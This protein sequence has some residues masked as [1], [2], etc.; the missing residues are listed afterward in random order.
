MTNAVSTARPR[1]KKQRPTVVAAKPVKARPRKNPIKKSNCIWHGENVDFSTDKNGKVKQ[2]IDCKKKHDV[3]YYAKNAEKIKTKNKTRASLPK[4]TPCKWHPW[5]NW[6]STSG[7]NCGACRAEINMVSSATKCDL[8]KG[9]VCTMTRDFVTSCMGKHCALCDYGPLYP[10]KEPDHPRKFS[11]D[12][13]NSSLPHTSDLSQM[14][15]VCNQCNRFKWIYTNEEV[16]EISCAIVSA[17]DLGEYDDVDVDVVVALEDET[18][19]CE[20]L[21]I[22]DRDRKRDCGGKPKHE[23]DWVPFTLTYVDAIAQLRVQHHCCSLCHL[24]L[25]DDDC[26]FDQTVAKNGYVAGKFTFMHQCCNMLK[27]D[28]DIEIAIETARRIVANWNSKTHCV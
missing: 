25:S 27:G 9:L 17:V 20:K 22:K 15:A 23:Q 11:L 10:M 19:M 8:D 3:V 16:Y 28:W 4:T 18:R 21:R 24:A 1:V 12:R 6:W 13:I 2:C 5:C 14:Q 7:D 26:T